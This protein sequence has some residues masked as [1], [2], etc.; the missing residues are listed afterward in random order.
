[1]GED[2]LKAFQSIWGIDVN[3]IAVIISRTRILTA[4]KILSGIDP[5]EA[6]RIFH[7]DFIGTLTGYMDA[8]YSVE[9]VYCLTPNRRSRKSLE[10]R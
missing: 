6:P 3:P 10:S 2:P 7:A 9:G 1:M 8:L 5:K 4:F